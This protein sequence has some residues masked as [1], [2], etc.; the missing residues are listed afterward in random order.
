MI[1]NQYRQNHHNNII[2]FIDNH[3]S[4][5]I[6]DFGD[7]IYVWKWIYVMRIAQAM[8][9][10]HIELAV[11]I[12]ETKQLQ[13]AASALGISQPAAS[14]MLADIEAALGTKLFIRQPSGMVLSAEGEVFMRH[15]RIVKSELSNI[16][17]E[18]IQLKTGVAGTV[19]VGAVTGPALGCLMPAINSLPAEQTKVRLYV[20]VAPSPTLFRGLEEAR[21]DFILGRAS[22]VGDTSDFHF[23]PGRAENISLLVHQTHPM[24]NRKNVNLA[25]LVD[26]PWVIQEEQNPIRYAVESAF[27]S[28]GITTP[29]HVINTSSLL[30]ALAQVADHQAVSP[31]TNEVKTLLMSGSVNARL[32]ELKTNLK[33]MV[34]PYYVIRDKRRTLT[35]ASENI[36]NRILEQI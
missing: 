14:R 34:P 27:Q 4:I 35:K 26:F 18:L 3:I 23:Y 1:P 19:R 9:P 31:Q 32:T 2:L 17:N 28:N 33:I 5:L 24:A 7:Q 16:D 12:A 8:K 11:K 10:R 30:I 6:Y 15:A 21:Y 20:D 22:A 13:I 29:Q 36:L 25:D